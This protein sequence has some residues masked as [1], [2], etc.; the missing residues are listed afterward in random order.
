MMSRKYDALV[1]EFQELQQQ[2]ATQQHELDKK[3]RASQEQ[4]RSLQEDFDEAQAELSSLDRQ[5]KHRLQEVQSKHITLQKTLDGLRDDLEQ[6]SAA[7]QES[8]KRL[9]QQDAEVGR[10]ESE[11]LDLKAQVGDADNLAAV[12]K[13][14]S[15]QVSHIRKLEKTNREQLAELRHF[16]QIHKAVE[17]VEE[18]KRALENK[19]RTM[20]DLRRELGEAQFQRQRLEDERSSWASY[21][22]DQEVEFDSP[23]ALARTLVQERSEKAVLLERLGSVQPEVSEKE[24]IIRALD[25][26]RSKLRAELEK[27]KAEGGGGRAKSR[28]E[29]QK[30][31]AV[32]EVEY[33][34]EQLR[35]F[36][37]EDI[38]GEVGTNFTGRANKR[39]QD[40]ESLVDQYRGELR[41]LNDELSK[42]EEKLPTLKR[43]AE[44]EPDERV[45]L[46]SRKNRKL[47][48]ELSNLQQSTTSLQAEL[49]ATKSQ[50]SS[51]QATARTRVLELRLNPTAEF[52]ALKFSMIT[53]LRTE[54]HALLA[55]LRGEPHNVKVV[56]ISSLESAHHEVRELEKVVAEKEKRML[57]LKQIWSAKSLELREAIMSILGWKVDVL[58]NGRFRMTSIFNLD[59]TD[60]QDEGD[61]SSLIFDGDNGTMKCSAGPKSPFALEILPLV[62]YWI[63]ERKEVPAFLSALTLD[64]FD[65][66][67]RAARMWRDED[68]QV[69]DD[70][71]ADGSDFLHRDV[72]GVLAR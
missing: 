34:R 12:K 68:M 1:K 39:M 37:N 21:L 14:M 28:L 17:I 24:L 35:T 38:T 54:N 64:L 41:T 18:E 61:S 51:F 11:V 60:D 16:R 40:L 29:R 59:T 44:E 67:T 31:L 27:L 43:S 48:A 58:P 20:D 13:E 8:Q 3:L 15:D 47:Q 10:L 49:A 63:E 30:A 7:L 42:R 6:R 62:R 65:K 2:T 36:D 66:T 53:T 23:E 4:T 45:G 19:V 46:L 69:Q 9:S 55:Q 26:E 57:R 56:P 22:Q 33:L 72:P 5:H 52:E 50:L 70:D 71:G 32:K 25:A